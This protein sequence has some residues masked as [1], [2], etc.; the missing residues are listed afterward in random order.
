[1]GNDDFDLKYMADHSD[2]L[3]LMNYDQHQTGSGPGPIAAQDWFVDNLKNV[4]KVVPK[5]KAICAIGSYGYDW[6]MSL[7]PVDPKHPGKAPKNFV[8][9]VLSVQEMS[10]QDAWQEAEDAD[11]QIELDPDSLNVH[12]A[13]DDD[14]A[15]PRPPPG[16]V[17]RR[18]DRAEPDACR[19]SAGHRDVRAVAAGAGRQ[20]AVED[21]GQ[22][23]HADPVK[24]LAQVEPGYDVDT[25][26]EG[27]I[28]HITRKMQTGHRVVTMDD[29]DSMPMGTAPSPQR[30]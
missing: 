21:L 26:G 5:E 11:A 2:G 14:D 8:P 7:P 20:L 10:T 19:A 1:M 23:V 15:C 12:F 22:A 25:E 13:Y 18:G 24:D 3:L 17:P 28:L 30:R 4:L 27:D 6:T 9:K 16:L 29:D